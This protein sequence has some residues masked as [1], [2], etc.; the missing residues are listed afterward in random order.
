M[1]AD[2]P[3]MGAPTAITPCKGG[4]L[5]YLGPAAGQVSH[6]SM[7]VFTWACFFIMMPTFIVYWCR[8]SSPSHEVST[9]LQE[10][11]FA[12]E[13]KLDSLQGAIIA[14]EEGLAAFACVL[15]E[16]LTERDASHRRAVVV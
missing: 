6:H 8:A 1:M 16:V 15:T 10:Q 3:V 7:S 4:R 9:E 12:R 14:W 11:L 5:L 13:R 2:V